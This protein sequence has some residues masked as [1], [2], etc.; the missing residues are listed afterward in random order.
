MNTACICLDKP[1]EGVSVQENCLVFDDINRAKP[2]LLQVYSIRL[3]W[4]LVHAMQGLLECANNKK[5]G[6]AIQYT[7]HPSTYR[8]L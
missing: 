7:M 1:S 8:D 4:D 5:T 6:V 3:S 2:F